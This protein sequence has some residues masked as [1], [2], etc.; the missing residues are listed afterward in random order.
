MLKKRG[1]NIIDYI[2]NTIDIFNK[3]KEEEENR[4]LGYLA[5]MY[6]NDLITVTEYHLISEM[7][8]EGTVVFTLLCTEQVYITTAFKKCIESCCEK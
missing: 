8:C 7:I 5:G 3:F 4:L 2:Q 1:T 6:W